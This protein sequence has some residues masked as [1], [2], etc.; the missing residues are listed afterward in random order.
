MN[1]AGLVVFE[2]LECGLGI[3][4]SL[5]GLGSQGVEVAQAVAAQTAIKPRAADRWVDELAHHHQQVIQRD[6]REAADLGHDSLLA[7]AGRGGQLMRAVR[8]VLGAIAL[9]PLRDGGAGNVV[10][11]GKLGLAER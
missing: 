1:E 7:R 11:L 6:Q 3:A 4:G 5:A 2:A 9:F 8:A 10:A